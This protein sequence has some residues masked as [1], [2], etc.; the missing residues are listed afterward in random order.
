MHCSGIPVLSH[1]APPKAE[2]M[3]S[4]TVAIAIP[5]HLVPAL[6]LLLAETNKHWHETSL[7][8]V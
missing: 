3:W 1:L 6:D 8:T 4:S 5:A 2:G 7:A